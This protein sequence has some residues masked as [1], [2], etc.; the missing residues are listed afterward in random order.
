MQ[1][2]LGFFQRLLTTTGEGLQL[3]SLQAESKAPGQ[4]R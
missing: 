4:L 1:A 2:D 3:R